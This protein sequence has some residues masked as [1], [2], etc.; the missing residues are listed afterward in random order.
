[1]VQTFHE[2]FEIIVDKIKIDYLSVRISCKLYN[3][4]TY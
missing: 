1:M 3:I 4:K 2:L